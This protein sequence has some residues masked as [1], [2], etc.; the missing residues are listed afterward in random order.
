MPGTAQ[1]G[2][3]SLIGICGPPGSGKTTL[4]RALVPLLGDA[5][6]IEMDDYQRMTELPLEQ[7]AGWFARGADHD[8]LPVPHLAEH[9]AL[10]K[11]GRSVVNPATGAVIRPARFIVLETHFGRA[12]RATGGLIDMLLWMDTPADVALAR[13]LRTFM[14]PWLAPSTAGPAQADGLAW[15]D[16]YLSSYLALVAELLVVQRQRLRGAADLLVDPDVPAPKVAAELLARL[17]LRSPAT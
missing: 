12:H 16:G 13:N 15:L 3:I 8:E 1:A 14:A 17:R 10:L 4:A 7:I 11:Q 2:P 9:L 5:V 6:H